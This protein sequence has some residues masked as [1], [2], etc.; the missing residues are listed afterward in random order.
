[1]TEST[2][3]T[4]DLGLDSLDHVEVIMA[5]EDEFQFEIPDKDAEK[6]MTPGDI[7]KYV[8]DK[9]ECWREMVPPDEA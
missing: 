1:M 8:C 6:L 9:E 2:H 4:N 5:I 7:I 3:F